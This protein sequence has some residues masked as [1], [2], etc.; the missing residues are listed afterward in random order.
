MC[1]SVSSS[2]RA[3]SSDPATSIDELLSGLGALVA[4]LEPGLIAFRRDVHAHPELAHEETRTT[5][6]IA[7][8]LAE[9]GIAFTTLRGTGLLVDLGAARPTRRVALRADLDALPLTERSGLPFASS[10]P[11]VSHACGHDVHTTVLLGAALALARVE[12]ELEA[13]GLAV[14]CIF[15][16]AE[17]VF[18]GGAEAVIEQGALDGVDVVYALHCD[19]TL[20]VG[21]VGLRVG[22]ITAASD[23]LEVRLRGAGGHTSRPHLTQDLTYALAKVVTDVPASLSRRVDPRSVVALVWGKISA[24]DAANVIPET[25]V[26]LGT[27]RCLD[28][29]V[30]DAIG[31]LLQELVHAAA[32][33][34]GVAVEVNHERGVPPVVNDAAAVAS[35]RSGI[36]ATLGAEAVA[37]TPQSLGGEDFSWMTRHVPG[38]LAR[39]GT[40]TPGGPSYDLHRPD[41]VVD[42]RAIGV[43]VSTFVGAALQALLVPAP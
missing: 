40:K 4:E 17:E 2:A 19:P 42:E 11:G 34:F 18:P 38:A 8:V 6:R 16:P 21:R 28:A 26:A 20:E 39:L 37:P 15:Q 13:R 25:G 7:E 14:R 9:A 43:G 10:W 30:W 1:F 33:P 22:P 36:T 31:P 41:L 12:A 32:A 23:H 24:G 29:E 5:T 3:A 35:L 27:V